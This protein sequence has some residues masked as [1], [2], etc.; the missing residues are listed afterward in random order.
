MRTLP[1]G[2]RAVGKLTMAHGLTPPQ[3]PGSEQSPCTIMGR[4]GPLSELATSKAQNPG[5]HSRGHRKK[6]WFKRAE[7]LQ[8]HSLPL[9]LKSP[10]LDAIRA[11]FRHH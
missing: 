10:D 7:E 9:N 1:N 11:G 4:S 3:K 2:G 6:K 8:K 5:P